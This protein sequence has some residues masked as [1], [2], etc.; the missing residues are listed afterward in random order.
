MSPSR[1][2]PPSRKVHV[3]RGHTTLTST[4]NC[5]RSSAALSHLRPSSSLLSSSLPPPPSL[6]LR[7]TQN[8]T[9]PPVTPSDASRTLK[10]KERG[11]KKAK[12]Y[13]EH[14]GLIL[15]ATRPY[16]VKIWM[17]D[18]FPGDKVQRQWAMDSWDAISDGVPIP[19]D[20][21]IRYVSDAPCEPNNFLP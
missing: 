11:R 6:N 4:C 9:Q 13:P 2:R 14:Q 19:D 1:T 17:F 7:N 15:A 12:D 20:G 10:A 3:F 8:R 18:P 16:Y 5:D 21:V